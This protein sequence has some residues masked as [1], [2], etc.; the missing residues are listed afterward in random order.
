V[1]RPLYLYEKGRRLST[2]SGAFTVEEGEAEIFACAVTRVDR[3]EIGPEAQADGEAL[4]LAIDNRIP[5]VFV[6]GAG[7]PVAHLSPQVTHHGRLHLA[8]ARAALDGGRARSIASA[9]VS[10]R[11]RNARALL[12]RLNR[13]RKDEG[14]AQAAGKLGDIL[15]KL[16]AAE[17]VASAR[18]VEAEAAALYWPA[19]GRTLREGFPFSQRVRH[20]PDSPV[21]LLLDFAAALLTRDVAT[22]AAQ[23]GLHPGFGILHAARDEPGPV[24]YDLVEPY[25]APL[26]EGFVVYALNNRIVSQQHFHRQDDGAPALFPQGRERFIRA[27]EA[28]LARPVRNL[29]R[30]ADTPWRAVIE[31]DIMAF[32]DALL[33]GAEFS[34]Y[35][36]GY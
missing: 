9:L 17:N 8:Q 32:C 34:A 15:D 25:R 12:R 23:H 29:R 28:W 26:C 13:R 21:N 33:S 22:I 30:G 6:S 35:D 7:A 16:D 24:A 14:V 3:I 31:G 1:V 5:V 11:V 20:P 4:R 19:W 2:R 27:Y 18:A 36:M 10:A